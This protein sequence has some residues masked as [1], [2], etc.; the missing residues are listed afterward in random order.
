MFFHALPHNYLILHTF[1]SHQV[2]FPLG[3]LWEDALLLHHKTQSEDSFLAQRLNTGGEDEL[4]E[5]NEEEKTDDDEEVEEDLEEDGGERTRSAVKQH[6]E[7][8]GEESAGA[9]KEE[10]EGDQEMG[11]S[12]SLNSLHAAIE[13]LRQCCCEGG[14]GRSGGG[15]AESHRV[16][17]KCAALS[18]ACLLRLR[19]TQYTQTHQRERDTRTP[20]QNL[21]T[22]DTEAQTHPPVDTHSAALDLLVGALGKTHTFTQECPDRHKY[23]LSVLSCVSMFEYRSASVIGFRL[24]FAVVHRRKIYRWHISDVMYVLYIQYTQGHTGCQ[25][26]LSTHCRSL[27][28]S[29]LSPRNIAATKGTKGAKKNWVSFSVSLASVWRRWEAGA[30]C[31][32]KQACLWCSVRRIV[33]WR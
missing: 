11:S 15:G 19:P 18:G 17:L 24:T 13:R 7:G 16:I 28:Q 10:G 22:P 29:P 21:D 32:Y 3:G 20:A 2:Q 23:N 33:S 30:G 6:E 27:E 8:R 1:S 4:E 12:S 25:M 5:E 31:Q 9:G 26:A 14:V